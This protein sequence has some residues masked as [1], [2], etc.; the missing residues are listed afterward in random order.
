MSWESR[1]WTTAATAGNQARLVL[2]AIIALVAIIGYYSQQAENPI[3]GEKQKVAMSTDEE[4]AIGL[5][6]EPEMEQQ[7]GGIH[8]D[9]RACAHVDQIGARLLK[10]FNVVI[11]EAGAKEP[12]S[13]QVPS[14]GGRQDDQCLRLARRA[15][16][17]HLRA[18]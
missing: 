16:V 15:G 12:L 9:P 4:I 1:L 10:A 5:Q 13:V 11:E 3:T 18:V 8:D 17:Y 7:F 6:A 14:P 2:A